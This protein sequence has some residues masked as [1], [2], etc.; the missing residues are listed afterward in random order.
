[1]NTE[2]KKKA[3]RKYLLSWK[4]LFGSDPREQALLEDNID[5]ARWTKNMEYLKTKSYL[6]TEGVDPLVVRIGH[7][8]AA[9]PSMFWGG[10]NDWFIA[11]YPDVVNYFIPSADRVDKT[12]CG[13]DL[14]SFMDEMKNFS[15][16]EQIRRYES[17][18]K[19]KDPYE[20]TEGE[21]I[22]HKLIE[23]QQYQHPKWNPVQFLLY[24]KRFYKDE[25][26][27]TFSLAAESTLS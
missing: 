3:I 13:A 2:E 24:L 25:L 16:R 18:C 10:K 7:F 21:L 27:K 6:T 17:I 20:E 15:P 8:T 1:M 12:I 23:S 26:K 22:Y 5:I 14:E 19:V 9:L 4:S 11:G